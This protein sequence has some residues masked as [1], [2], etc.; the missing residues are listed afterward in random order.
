MNAYDFIPSKDVAAYCK[1][2]GHTFNPIETA[3][4]IEHSD[5]PIIEKNKLYQ[6]LID[7]YPDMQFHES[8][9][10]RVRTGL[11]DYLRALIDWNERALKCF[12]DPGKKDQISYN[13]DYYSV[14]QLGLG[15]KIDP[16][17]FYE[18]RDEYKSFQTPKELWDDVCPYW[19]RV[20]DHKFIRMILNGKRP[21][22]DYTIYADFNRSGEIIRLDESSFNPKVKK[23][24]GNLWEI[25]VHI[26]VPFSVGDIVCSVTDGEAFPYVLH[27]L[28]QFD[29]FSSEEMSGTWGEYCY[30]F[31]KTQEFATIFFITKDGDLAKSMPDLPPG[32]PM[33]Q[34]WG[35][36]PMDL[37]VYRGKFEGAYEKLLDF[38][39]I[40]KQRNFAQDKGMPDGDDS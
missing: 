37:C 29:G 23:Y 2:I 28:P 32:H 7:N 31:R 40:V 14:G 4:L 21:K 35:F 6:E 19:D 39:R 30:E 34:G 20:K 36:D 12:Y 26:P 13:L 17:R 22:S 10:L 3:W 38:S 27:S 33:A 11:H 8:V 5:R 25:F 9:K 18:K 1:E 16:I 24:P 15:R